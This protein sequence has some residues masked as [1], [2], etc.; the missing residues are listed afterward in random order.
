MQNCMSALTVNWRSTYPG[1]CASTLWRQAPVT[2]AAPHKAEMYWRVSYQFAANIK[3]LKTCYM[4][5]S[6]RADF[7]NILCSF[8][9]LCFNLWKEIIVSAPFSIIG[10]QVFWQQSSL[11]GL[12]SIRFNNGIAQGDYLLNVC[13]PVTVAMLTT[14]WTAD[15]SLSKRVLRKQ[16]LYFN[17]CLGNKVSPRWSCN[18]NI[19]FWRIKQEPQPKCI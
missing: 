7:G 3:L 17:Q 2:P 16:C 12:P 15:P 6:G 9:N 19:I 5:K 13:L 8:L 10:S 14:S 4:W 1:M 18:A 11:V